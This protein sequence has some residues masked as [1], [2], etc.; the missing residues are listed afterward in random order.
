MYCFV[1]TEL[2]QY[3]RVHSYVLL[4]SRAGAH[5]LSVLEFEKD[6]D[7]NGHMDF[8]AATA[9]CLCLY[10]GCMERRCQAQA[11]ASLVS[12]HVFARSCSCVRAEPTRSH[13]L[14]RARRAPPG[15]E[16]CRPHHPCNRHHD[17]RHR[18]T[19]M[20]SSWHAY[21][22]TALTPLA[23]STL[24]SAHTSRAYVQLSEH[25]VRAALNTWR[26]I[27]HSEHIYCTILRM[28]QLHS[29]YNEYFVC[30]PF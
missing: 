29:A 15:E 28:Y 1:C 22:L 21:A 5:E 25:F 11:R 2:C 30:N 19:R 9:V 14:D 17:G 7:S 10:T 24:V 12:W 20:S 13:V 26:A 8:I 3:I 6:D 18:R 27:F 16:D 4:R 23:L